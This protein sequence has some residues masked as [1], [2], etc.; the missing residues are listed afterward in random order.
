MY[1]QSG[2]PIPPGETGKVGGSEDKHKPGLYNDSNITFVCHDSDSVETTHNSK[3]KG[4]SNTISLVVFSS[5][6]AFDL[7]SLVTIPE[8]G[9]GVTRGVYRK[10]GPPPP[11][12]VSALSDPRG[13]SD[14]SATQYKVHV[15]PS[16]D[17]HLPTSKPPIVARLRKR[18]QT[19]FKAKFR[20]PV[21][22]T[23]A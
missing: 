12:Q 11:S 22:Q 21:L 10:E 4:R 6:H 19:W 5:P 14:W 3:T 2:K 18:I 23:P 1:Y 8:G 15:S 20:K 17:Q 13:S 7:T 9:Q 16:H